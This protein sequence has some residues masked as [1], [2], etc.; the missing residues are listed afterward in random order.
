MGQKVLTLPLIVLFF[1]IV[2]AFNDDD[3]YDEDDELYLDDR[4]SGYGGDSGGGGI[5]PLAALIAPLA[6]LALLG[7]AAAV[8]INPVLVQLAV[9]NGGR[10]KRRQ[11]NLDPLTQKRMT[12]IDV[13]ENFLAKETDFNQQTETLVANYLDCSGLASIDNKCLERLVCFYAAP[14]ENDGVSKSEKDV[15]AII[16]Y[17]LM[18]NQKVDQILKSRMKHAG[19]I[20]RMVGGQCQKYYCPALDQVPPKF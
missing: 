1:G 10:R 3:Y 6:G 7:A 19:Q 5:N 17:Q 16:L 20:S 15:I 8:S 13:L 9:I 18:S 11:A 2:L 12:E 14:K 4:D